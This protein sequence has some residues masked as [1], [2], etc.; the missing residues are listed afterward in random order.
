MA[1]PQYE[2]LALATQEVLRMTLDFFTR[3][4]LLWSLDSQFFSRVPIVGDAIDWDGVR[5][6]VLEVTH[7][8]ETGPAT[9]SGVATWRTWTRIILM[10]RTA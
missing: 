9:R 3:G 2:V 7:C 8:Y 4:K 10:E 6:T 1:V 5:W